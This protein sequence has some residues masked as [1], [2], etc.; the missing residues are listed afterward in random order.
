MSSKGV[1]ILG[2][3]GQVELYIHITPNK[4][5]SVSVLKDC[6]PC[7]LQKIPTIHAELFQPGL[8]CCTTIKAELKCETDQFPKFLN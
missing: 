7:Q 2:R 3:D 4:F 6:C 1:N 8:G 5:G